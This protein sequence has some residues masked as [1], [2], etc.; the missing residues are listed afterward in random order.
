ML[1]RS[2]VVLLTLGL[3]LLGA[4]ESPQTPAAPPSLVGYW[5]SSYGDGFEVSG[6]TFTQYDDASK[7]VSF[8]GTI[9]GTPDMTA[10]AGSLTLQITDPGTWKK[11]AGRYYVVRWKALSARGVKESSASNY[12]AATP[13]PDTQAG[14]EAAFTEANGSFG[15]Y[16]DYARQ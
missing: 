7:S 8:A 1:Q 12:P 5:K 15:Y 16:G 11:T 3:L 14:A 10:V 13:E 4:C 2:F 6:S 9:Q